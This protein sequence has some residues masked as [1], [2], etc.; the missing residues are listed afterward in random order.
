MSSR[1]DSGSTSKTLNL[2]LLRFNEWSGSENLEWMTWTLMWLNWSVAKINAT[3]Q[4]LDIYKLGTGKS[5]FPCFSANFCRIFTHCNCLS[6]SDYDLAWA[7]HLS[8]FTILLEQHLSNNEASSS[9]TLPIFTC[10]SLKQAL[11]WVHFKELLCK[12]PL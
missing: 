5:S 6:L 1:F 7:P 3:L 4:F 9:M 2:S 10:V 12:L 8:R 11:A